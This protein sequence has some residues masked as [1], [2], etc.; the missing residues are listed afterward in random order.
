MK[1]I[2]FII[3]AVFTFASSGLL[4]HLYNRTDALSLRYILWKKGLHPYPKEFA[5]FAV[6][7]DGNRDELIRGKTKA[8]VKAIFPDAS[9]TLEPSEISNFYQNNYKK[10]LEEREHLWFGKNVVIF[11]KNGLGDKITILKG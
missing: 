8:E 6:I 7:A 2:L 10:E 4:A 9:E 3:I 11:F 5:S 1:K